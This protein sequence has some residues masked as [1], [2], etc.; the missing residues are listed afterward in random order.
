MKTGP[1]DTD[2]LI[3]ILAKIREALGVGH[4]PMLSDFPEEARKIRRRAD[5]AV[6][7]VGK[8]SLYRRNGVLWLEHENSDGYAVKLDGVRERAFEV[9]L[10]IL[11]DKYSD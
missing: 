5:D 2:A 9:A 8:Y 7:E 4:K 3:A 10:E 1:K 11:F 6:I